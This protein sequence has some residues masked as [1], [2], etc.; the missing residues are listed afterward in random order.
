MQNKIQFLRVTP[1]FFSKTGHCP[2][3][4]QPFP[5]M[6]S[7]TPSALVTLKHLATT[8]HSLLSFRPAWNQDMHPPFYKPLLHPWGPLLKMVLEPRPSFSLLRLQHLGS[9]GRRATSSVSH[10]ALGK[11]YFNVSWLY[12]YCRDE[13]TGM[14][15]VF[16]AEYGKPRFEVLR[17][18]Y[19]GLLWV[20]GHKEQ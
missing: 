7:H 15:D 8:S 2:P 11:S 20:K 1:Q 4:P 18:T 12:S 14:S 10:S 3:R 9:G 5:A 16:L 13:W 19:T 17:H 6:A